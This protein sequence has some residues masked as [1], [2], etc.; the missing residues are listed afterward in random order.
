MK[1][2]E[3][4]LELRSV[5]EAQSAEQYVTLLELLQGRLEHVRRFTEPIPY[6]GINKAWVPQDV[7]PVYA[8]F[9]REAGMSWSR[10]LS[11]AHERY[12]KEAK[13]KDYSCQGLFL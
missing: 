9:A 3:E 7:F 12:Q 8:N 5:T 13:G 11:L 1:I 6:R 10:A 4:T 2:T